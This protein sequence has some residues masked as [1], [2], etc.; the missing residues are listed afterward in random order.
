L[1]E[2]AAQDREQAEEKERCEKERIRASRVGRALFKT[3]RL[4]F[5]ADGSRLSGNMTSG[6]L[7]MFG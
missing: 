7:G 6:P 3:Q 1:V 4:A 5:E 2:F